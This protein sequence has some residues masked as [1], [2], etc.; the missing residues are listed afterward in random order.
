MTTISPAAL[1]KLARIYSKSTGYSLKTISQYSAGSTHFLGGL[2]RGRPVTNHRAERVA[3]W[4]NHNWPAG[5]EWPADIARP[6]SAGDSKVRGVKVGI[7]GNPKRTA[8]SVL[9]FSES[10]M[11][12][13]KSRGRR[14][15]Q[16]RLSL[17]LLIS[18][19]IAAGRLRPAL[20]LI[21]I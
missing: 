17:G 6:V 13:H 1:L 12:D 18:S 19:D 16:V 9:D 7:G 20:F 14:G 10:Q 15:E 8:R 5:V 21:S 2:E 11:P 3:Q 4:F